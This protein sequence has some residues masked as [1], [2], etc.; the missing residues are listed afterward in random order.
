MSEALYA[1]VR[2]AVGRL[3]SSSAS[4]PLAAFGLADLLASGDVVERNAAFAFAEAQG[5]VGTTT[6]VISAIALAGVDAPESSA[7]AHPLSARSSSP[8][9]LYGLL[10]SEDLTDVLVEDR[11]RPSWLNVRA[12]SVCPSPLDPD[13]LRVVKVDPRLHGGDETRGSGLTASRARLACAA[14]TLGACETMLADAIRY[15]SERRQ[16]GARLVSFQ[17]VAHLLAW[18]ATEVHQLRALLDVS[19]DG[20]AIRSPNP[21]QAMATKSLAGRV[22]RRV[23]QITLQAT[24]GMGFTWEYSHNALHRRVLTLD[25]VGG[26][27]EALNLELGR[28]LRASVEI[29]SAYPA[30]I[31]LEALAE[32]RLNGDLARRG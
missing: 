31:S 4:D 7:Y 3:L 12:L 26:G 23:A 2:E 30:L 22:S 32:A 9:L 13:Y 28:R 11:G 15:A 8:P 25:A 6:G 21:M 17:A 1:E 27:A 18:G 5:R 29:D 14:E 16:F 10:G 19:L 24:G 20:D